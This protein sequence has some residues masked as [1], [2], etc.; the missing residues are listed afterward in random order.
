MTISR[1]R[2][3]LGALALLALL[4]G[5]AT[6]PPGA[7]FPRAQ[8][9]ALEKPE[10]TVIGR[11]IAARVAGR[12]GLSGFKLLPRGLDSFAL[13]VQM[14]DAAEKTLDL[15]Y[16]VIQN[17]DSGYLLM[18]AVLRATKRGVNVRLLIDDPQAQAQQAQITPLVKQAM[19]DLLPLHSQLQAAH[20]QA[21]QA[22]TQDTVDRTALEAARVAHLQLADQASKRLVQLIADVDE[23]L[24]PAQ[25]SALAVHLQKMHVRS[26]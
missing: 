3:A 2:T 21:I 26:Q 4:G 15:Q 22:L 19:A 17:D 6:L 24:T 9:V 14:A 8:S 18:D 25:R 1:L 12:N 11:Q 16:F 13:R 5:C 20:T 23:V 7:D 10:A